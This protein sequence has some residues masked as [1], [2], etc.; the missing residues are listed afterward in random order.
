MNLSWN[1]RSISLRFRSLL[2][3]LAECELE[4]AFHVFRQDSDFHRRIKA[5]EHVEQ[6]LINVGIETRIS[7][8]PD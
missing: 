5:G 2:L 3:Q 7:F 6:I 4:V 8:W 1:V